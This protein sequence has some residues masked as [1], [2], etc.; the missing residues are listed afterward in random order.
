MILRNSI[1]R[2]FS[3]PEPSIPNPKESDIYL[4]SFPKSGNTWLRYLLAYSI[5]PATNELDLRDMAAYI[6]SFALKHDAEVMLDPN[7][8]CNLIKHRIIKEHFPYNEVA[9]MYVKNAIYLVRDGR[10]AMV[11]YWHFCNQRDGTNIS[12]NEFIRQSTATR[13]HFGPWRDHVTGWLNAPINNKLI[14]RYEDLKEDTLGSLQRILE[15]VD[16]DV[17]ETVIRSAIEK[18]S[19]NAMKKLEQTK[20]FNLEQLKNVKFVRKGKVGSWKESFE[21]R[22][23]AEF[24]KCHGHGVKKLGYEW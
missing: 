3:N 19:F 10:D 5:W 1:R 6:P 7:A 23:I 9:R 17:E 14:V 4:V 13:G 16:A 15:F 20:G 18:A 22:D 11:S 24:I 8:P 2:L 21:E 12:F